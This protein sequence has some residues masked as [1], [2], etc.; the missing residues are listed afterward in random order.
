MT[1]TINGIYSL[2]TTHIPQV[3]TATL[4]LTG[5]S[6]AD[7]FTISGG[8]IEVLGLFMHIT[9]AVSAD[10][11]TFQWQLDPTVG[12]SNTDLC[13]T[14][15]IVSAALGDV[16]YILGT[17]ASALQKAANGTSVAL[18]CT[19]RAFL[20]PGGIDAVLQNSDPGTGIATVY[21][22]Y[23]RMTLLSVVT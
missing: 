23:R 2:E 13:G 15:D 21:L 8:P 20:P 22:I 3:A 4:P 6:V 18:S 16:F 10:A 14:A 7:V 12:A 9:T 11:C 5:G 1:V 17:S 19:A